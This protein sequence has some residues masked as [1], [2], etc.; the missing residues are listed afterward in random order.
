[1]AIVLKPS[2][3]RRPDARRRR[4]HRRLASSGL[5]KGL[6]KMMRSGA[7]NTSETADA[8][9]SACA[10]FEAILGVLHEHARGAGGLTS[11]FIMAATAA[12]DGRDAVLTAPAG[13]GIG[14]GGPAGP[15]LPVLAPGAGPDDVAA[16]AAKLADDL[17]ARLRAA[18][19]DA[20]NPTDQAALAQAARHAG[21]VCACLAEPG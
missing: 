11:A 8:A 14:P 2:T 4:S 16:V 7:V 17:A 3:T 13:S 12:A 9:A 21:T 19:D 5:R 20:P 10:A 6:P 1:M 18:A 15:I